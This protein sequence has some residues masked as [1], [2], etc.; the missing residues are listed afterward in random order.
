M[1]HQSQCE[2]GQTQIAVHGTPVIRAFCHCQNCQAFNQAPYADVAVFYADDVDLPSD[3][4]VE[5]TTY[6]SNSVGVPRGKCRQCGKPA[7]EK[8]K[9]P[10]LPAMVLIP[11]SNFADSSVLPAPV[12]HM[13]YHRRQADADDQLPKYNS[14]LSSQLGFTRRFLSA[15]LKH[16]R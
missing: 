6:S 10:G 8:M 15:L 13:F 1:S 11:A 16:K 14:F 7:I 9:V 5:Y 3:E 2:C 4:Q 12:C